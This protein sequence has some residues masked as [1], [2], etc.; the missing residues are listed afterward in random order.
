MSVPY[1]PQISRCQLTYLQSARELFAAQLG[2]ELASA[3][4]QVE[5]CLNNPDVEDEVPIDRETVLEFGQKLKV[6]LREI[7]KDHVTD[8]FDIG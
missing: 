3:L 4:K 7:W 5:A 6:A 8:V 1:Y 2:Q